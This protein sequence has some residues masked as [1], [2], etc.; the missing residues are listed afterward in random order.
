MEA[1]EATD[2]LR[3]ERLSALASSSVAVEREVS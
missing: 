1:G 2:N 3:Y